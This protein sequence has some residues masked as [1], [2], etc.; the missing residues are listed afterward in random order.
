MIS[1]DLSDLHS[2]IDVENNMIAVIDIVGHI[3]NNECSVCALLATFESN[4]SF[5][6]NSWNRMRNTSLH[7]EQ[8]KQRHICFSSILDSD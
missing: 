4:I 1:L 5:I 6:S 2:T 3:M 8:R 7:E